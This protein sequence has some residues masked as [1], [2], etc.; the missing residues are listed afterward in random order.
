M[1]KVI[2]RRRVVRKTNL[3][4]NEKLNQFNP[5]ILNLGDISI[6]SREVGA[7]A[8]VFDLAGFTK[9][10]NQVDPH[11]AVPKYLSNFL[12]W[13]FGKI[14]GEL[15]EVSYGDR[16]KLWAELPF[17]AK[18]LGD[19]VLFLWNTRGLTETLTCKIITTLYEICYAYKHEFYPRISMAVDKPPS[20]LRCG[21]ARGR[22]FS[23]GN[24]RDYIGHCINNASRLQKL[25]LLTFCFPHRGFNI[26]EYMHE[27][28]RRIFVQKSVTIRGIGENELI[29]VI[30]EEFDRLPEKT[31]E[32]FRN[33]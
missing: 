18:F 25:S 30:K 8:A 10:C 28:Y 23:V 32:L 33:P 9:F 26:Q 3:I 21:I 19:G 2:L 12:D 13:L 5:S 27:G 6:P 15:T 7:I 4:A 14:R 24:G 17:L 16:K 20:V 31:K 11:L 29:W 22:V 1:R